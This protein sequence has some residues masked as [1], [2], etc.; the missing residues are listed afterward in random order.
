MD[1]E[2]KKITENK[3]ADTMIERPKGFAVGKRHFYL[4]PL[5]LGKAVLLKPYTE[6]LEVNMEVMESNPFVEALRLV[7]TKKRDVCLILSYHTMKSKDEVFDNEKVGKTTDY[8]YNNTDDEDLASL[9]L[10]VLTSDN[11][12]KISSFLGI[13]KESDRLRQVIKAK[14][15]K[16]DF[17]FGGLSLY[18]TILDFACERYKWTKDYVMWGISYTNLQLMIADRMQSVYLTDEEKRRVSPA[19]LHAQGQTVNMD[20]PKNKDAYKKMDWR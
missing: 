7:E 2:K 16:N 5:T 9:F 20:D 11:T 12:K 6:A 1:D 18:G 15:S 19:L 14:Q 4:Y 3:I 8:L 13:E 10:A 17:S